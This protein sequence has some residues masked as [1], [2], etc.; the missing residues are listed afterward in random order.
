M[1]WDFRLASITCFC[2]RHRGLDRTHGVD[3]W[4]LQVELMT[5]E[6]AID[7]LA[8]VLDKVVDEVCSGVRGPYC[9]GLEKLSRQ[10]KQ[11]SQAGDKEALRQHLGVC[12]KMRRHTEDYRT[13]W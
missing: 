11:A 2:Q 8:E 5:E 4:P 10:L 7:R 6:I 1:N 3:E 13:S 9:L 12:T